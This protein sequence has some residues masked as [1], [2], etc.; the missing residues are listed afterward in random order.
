MPGRG[1]RGKPKP[2]FPSFPTALGNRC[3]DFHIPTAPATGPFHPK[4][5]KKKPQKGARHRDCLISSLQAHS[6]IRK[7]SGPGMTNVKS[8]TPGSH[9]PPVSPDDIKRVWI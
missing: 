9:L 8:L 1:K 5:N 6:W 7:C 4:T 3:C 2:G